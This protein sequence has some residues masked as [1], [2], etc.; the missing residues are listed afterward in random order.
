VPIW[1][2][3]VEETEEIEVEETEEIEVERPMRLEEY[4]YRRLD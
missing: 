4:T 1:R 2:Q 3:E